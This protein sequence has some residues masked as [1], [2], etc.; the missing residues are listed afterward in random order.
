MNKR[1]HIVWAGLIL[2]LVLAACQAQATPSASSSTG[3]SGAGNFSGAGGTGG[4]NFRNNPAFETRV[5]GDPALA[6]RIASGGFGA[7]RA[8]ATPTPMPTIANVPTPTPTVITGSD[9]AAQ[10]VQGYFTDLQNGNFNSASA[11]LSAFSLLEANTTASQVA[12]QLTQMKAQGYAWSGLKVVDSQPFNAST[13]LVHV[14]YTL[15]APD[16]KTNKPVQSQKDELWPVRQEAGQ[17][18]YNWQNIIDFNTL[19]VPVQEIYGLTIQPLQL[20]RYSD[21]LTM[22]VLAQNATSEPIVIG[23]PNEVLATFH[24][25]SQSVDA[26]DTRYIIDSYRSYTNVNI[27]VNGLYK[28][29]PTSVDLI[30][31]PSYPDQPW[32]TFNLGS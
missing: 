2:T 28:T 22:T 31:S 29:F 12:D 19:T 3:G 9:L 11:L 30:K 18:L 32:F 26:V 14:Q 23:Q 10:T 17:W 16:P 1:M 6:T 13:I 20:T 7:G 5:A 8:T 21:H 25:G 4:G 24:F 27:T 15:T